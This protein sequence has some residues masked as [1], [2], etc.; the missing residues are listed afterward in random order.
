M[1]SSVTISIATNSAIAASK[2]FGWIVTGSP[3]L[4]AE[5]IHSLADVGNQVLLKVGEVRGRGGPDR[6]HPFG[7]A[8][9]DALLIQAGV[10]A[11]FLTEASLQT[12]G[13]TMHTAERSHVLPEYQDSLVPSHLVFQGLADRL[14]HSEPR[15]L[16]GGRRLR[17]RS[18]LGWADPASHGAECHFIH[19]RPCQ[20]HETIDVVLEPFAVA[21][22]E[23][24]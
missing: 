13:H 7:R 9:N 22:S 18:Q 1:S 4:F 21:E 8:P 12:L 23:D 19:G 5:T 10:E 6:V 15:P 24:R 11:A 17:H 16:G 20:Q 3:T 14:L 2:G